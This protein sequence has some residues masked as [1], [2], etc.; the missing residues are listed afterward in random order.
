MDSY[1]LRHLAGKSLFPFRSG[2]CAI[3]I[4]RKNDN[5]SI[6]MI[7]YQLQIIPVA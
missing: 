7:H 4:G 5:N 3:P 1:L 2:E 6:G